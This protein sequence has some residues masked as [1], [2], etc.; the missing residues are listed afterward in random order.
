MTDLPKSLFFFKPESEDQSFMETTD[1]LSA[2]LPGQLRSPF[3]PDHSP[4]EDSRV[5]IRYCLG[6]PGR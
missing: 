6:E 2:L 3:L 4:S 5:T 1:D